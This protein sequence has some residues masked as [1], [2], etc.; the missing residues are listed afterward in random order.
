MLPDADP[1]DMASVDSAPLAELRS[2]AA[3]SRATNLAF[4]A[5]SPYDDERQAVVNHVVKAHL[6]VEARWPEIAAGVALLHRLHAALVSDEELEWIVPTSYEWG[7][8]GQEGN[9]LY[10]IPIRVVDGVDH[11]YLAHK[12]K[13]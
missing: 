8:P 13:P 7:E 12:V 5:P 2:D 3:H 6:R 9:Q 4:A 1:P 11:L 10:G